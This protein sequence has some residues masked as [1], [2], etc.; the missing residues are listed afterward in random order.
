M[1]NAFR[2]RYGPWALVTGA[3]SGIG[4]ELAVLV[5]QRGLDVLL[6]GRDAQRLQEVAGAIQALGRRTKIVASD[7]STHAGT[8][9]LL[10]AAA[11][12]EVGLLVPAAGFGVGGEY[13]ALPEEEALAMMRLNCENVALLL[14]HLTPPMVARRRGGVLLVASMLAYHGIPYAALYAAT[15]AFVQ[16]LGEALAVELQDRGVEVVVTSPGP[17]ETGF[18]TRAGMRLGKTMQARDVALASL[19]ALG[20]SRVVLPGALTKLLHNATFGLPRSAKVRVMGRI[21]R[22]MT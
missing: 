20:R 10:D 15:K 21:M 8:R 18:A 3:S 16:S 2:D 19:R 7:L 22:G 6:A 13:L 14:M 1:D 11:G 4:R 5:A 12:L 9:D 17:T